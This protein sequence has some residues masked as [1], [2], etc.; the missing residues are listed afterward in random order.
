MTDRE[1]EI[2]DALYFTV[3]FHQLM[4]E[5][6]W[7]ENEVKQELENV[8]RKGWVKCFVR[9]TEEEVEDVNVFERAYKDLQ[10]LATKKG[11]FEHNSR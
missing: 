2:I 8:L 9:E 4:Q 10:Y 6:G 1:F 7:S 3:S 11:L 5:L